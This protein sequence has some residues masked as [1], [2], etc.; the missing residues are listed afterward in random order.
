MDGNE[1]NS[2]EIKTRRGGGFICAI[3]SWGYLKIL[4][5][6][7]GVDNVVQFVTILKS[8]AKLYNCLS[9]NLGSIDD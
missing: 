6:C 1:K 2:V 5:K 3:A 4:L 8:V 9:Y 7:Y